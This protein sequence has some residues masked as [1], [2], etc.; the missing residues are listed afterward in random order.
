MRIGLFIPCYVDAFHPEVGIA[1]LELLERLG[2]EVDFPVDQ[3]CC[4]Q[5]M[6][7][8]LA[9][10]PESAAT[11]AL[12]V[13]NF[14]PYDYVVC[15]SGSLAPTMCASHF[16][17]VR[18]DRR[19]CWRVRAVAPSNWW[20]SCTTCCASRRSRGREFPHKVALSPQLPDALRGL[21]HARSPSELGVAETWSKPLDAARPSVEGAAAR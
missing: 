16:D 12:F 19:R 2:C 15:P 11:E 6:T 17:A 20:S 9:A 13:R 14:E 10:T 3:T 8:A 5:P 1:T 7:N 18:A 4:G 21:R